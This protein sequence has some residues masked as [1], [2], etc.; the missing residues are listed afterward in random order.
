MKNKII[1]IHKII[2]VAV[3]LI[4]LAVTPIHNSGLS[5]LASQICGFAM[6]MFILLGLVCLFNATRLVDLNTKSFLICLVCI[7]VTCCFGGWLTWEYIVGLGT[8]MDISLINIQKALLLSVSALFAYIL[9][10]VTLVW[11]YI[12]EQKEKKLL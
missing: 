6:F 9:G 4:H 7:S 5:D 12:L 10:I 11:A 3:A 1:T 8:D 2:I